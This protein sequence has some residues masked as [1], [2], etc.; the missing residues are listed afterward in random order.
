MEIRQDAKQIDFIK[1]GKSMLKHKKSF[2]ISLPTAFIIACFYVLCI[3]RWYNTT[4][5]LAPETS[6]SSLG[7][8]GA[9]ALQCKGK[10]T[11]WKDGKYLLRISERTP[12]I[13]V[14]GKHNKIY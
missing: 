8:L 9:L 13:C 1:M 11:G 5:E 4:V 7:S 10:D 3:P 14:V 12:K 2:L 6:S